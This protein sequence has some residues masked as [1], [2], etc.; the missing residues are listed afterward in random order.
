MNRIDPWGLLDYEAQ[1]LGRTIP[2]SINVGNYPS[3]E[4]EYKKRLG[5]AIENINKHKDKLSS[6]D[7]DILKNLVSIVVVKNS[8]AKR[9]FMDEICGKFTLN[10]DYIKDSSVEHIGSAMFHDSYHKYQYEKNGVYSFTQSRGLKAEE[11]A[12]KYQLE[13]GKKIGLMP[14]EQHHL[15]KIIKDPTLIEKYIHMHPTK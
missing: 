6:E 13:V 7:I 12:M 9:P 5:W 10:E 1:L 8:V 2:I 3:L 11:D 4:Q 15:E 14:H